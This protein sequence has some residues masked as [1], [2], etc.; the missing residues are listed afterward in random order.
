MW[1]GIVTE[2]VSKTENT[3]PP[4]Q[5]L[6]LWFP[7]LATDRLHRERDSSHGAERDD[8]PLVVTEKIRGALR[9][10]AV[11]PRASNLGLTRGL[12]L[13]DARSRIPDLAVAEADAKGDARFIER[14]A[15]F[16][17]RFTPSVA[18]DLPDGLVLDITGCAHLFGGEA[19]L[20]IKILANLR[21]SGLSV[22]SS[23]AG[24]PDAAR[25][26]ARFSKVE[27]APPGK[28]EVLVKRLP[29]AALAGLER[30]T[31][32]AL[33]RA[34]LKTI[35][36]LSERP[37]QVLATR[38]GQDL[39]TY[40]MRTLG[41]E[42]ARI[43]PLRPLPSVVVDQHF[44]EPFTQAEALE[45]VLA[46][47]L[48]DAGRVMQERD[49]GG[50]VFEASFFRSDGAVRRIVVRTGRP[51]RDA[52]AVLRLYRERLDALSDP[53]DTGFGFDC[54]RLAVPVTEA[55]NAAQPHLNGHHL[56]GEESGNDAVGDLV[57]RL[58]VRFGRD[59]VL[60]FEARDTHD[61]DHDVRLVS[62]A[63]TSA[64]KNRAAGRIGWPR[65][66]P[67]EPPIRPLQLF[68]PPQSIEALAE[69]PDGPPLRFRW[70]RVLHDVTRLEGPQR[71]APEWWRK[72]TGA[73]ARDYYRVEDTAGC[74][75]WIFRQGFYGR[76][77]AHPR[78]FLHGVFA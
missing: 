33:S 37:S 51:S 11:D 22:R 53:I 6:A 47:L 32:I 14:L 67:G 3:A 38:F 76:G 57:D 17:E 24:T 56:D 74:R 34:G 55:L 77:D 41:R 20:Q 75:F 27:I 65:L 61:P 21:D 66:E 13:T 48:E 9:I 69:V 60:R 12:T 29:I 44:P 25:A 70:R 39:V 49:E 72:A 31:V 16:C 15:G 43:T 63:G 1:S 73:L 59:R 45:S 4:R 18:L 40:L 35:G 19:R 36:D 10:N 8:R 2:D 46:S 62:A 30:E 26:L 58:I 28:S 54:I 71:I 5:Y 52:P 42:D 7:F 64:I 68:D 50:R 78:W 23:I